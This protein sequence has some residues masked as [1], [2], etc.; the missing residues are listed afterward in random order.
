MFFCEF[1]EIFNNKYFYRTPP[2]A[3]SLVCGLKFQVLRIKL[4]QK[5]SKHSP[6]YTCDGSLFYFY[7]TFPKIA[8][9][10]TL[11]KANP[12]VGTSD[13]FRKNKICIKLKVKCIKLQ[14]NYPI[15]L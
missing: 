7:Q 15:N 10:F 1:C 2:V 14:T 5:T 6:K 13:I 4:F 11:K 3:A 12:I 9:C 8:L